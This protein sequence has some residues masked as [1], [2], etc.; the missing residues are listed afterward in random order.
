M[1]KILL[2]FCI[3]SFA[4]TAF[5]QLPQLNKNNIPAV[6][7]A[8]TLE[9]K[10]RLIMGLGMNI[11]GDLLGPNLAPPDTIKR[12]NPVPGSAGITYAVPRLG[13]PAIILADGPAGLRIDPTR[14][15]D[16]KK[17]YCTAFP[18]GTMLAS[19]WNDALV[20]KVGKAM[21]NEV[22]E[23]GVD[24]YLAPALNTH[25]NVLGGRNFEYYSEDPLISGRTAAAYINGVQ[26][27]GVGTSIK[28]FA[29][30]NH[31]A[32]RM[33]ID[34]QVSQRAMRE[35]YLRGFEYAIT[36]SKPWTVMSSYNKINGTYTSQNKGLITTILQDEWKFK[37]LVVTDW[38]SGD[39]GA[40]Q[41]N[42]GNHMIMPGTKNQY[43]QI[44]AASKDGSLSEERL[45][46]NVEK[47]LELILRSNTFKKYKY[48]DKPN[49][50]ENVT[51]AIDAATEGIV[52]LKN[53]DNSLP[54]N[55]KKTKIALLG[56]AS[57]KTVTGGSGSGDVNKAYS[58]SIYQGL[59]NNFEVN[60]YLQKDYVSYMNKAESELPKPTIWFMPMPSVAEKEITKAE[61]Q[62]Y[63]TKNDV[64]VLTIRRTSGEFID[65]KVEDDYLLND[66]EKSNIKNVSEAFHAKKKKLIVLLNIGGVIEM[67]SWEANADAILLTWQGGQE[68]GKA[69]ASVVNGEVN[70]SG[71]LA[72]TF[73]VKYE[74]LASAEGFPGT[75]DSLPT[76]VQYRDGIYVGYR[77][78]EKFKVPVTY[79]FGYGMSYT[80]FDYSNIKISNSS[81]KD[82]VLVTLDVTNTGTLAGKEVV[83]LYLGAPTTTLDKPVKELKAFGKTELLAPGKKVKM[84]FTINKIDLASFNEA[85]SAWVA[86][87]GA[88]KIY[89]GASSKNIKL[90]TGFIL[91]KILVVKKVNNVLAPVEK[92]E[93][94]K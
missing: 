20:Q 60:K 52:L 77:Y 86:D 29:A 75:P 68:A 94:L 13:I 84:T 91:P 44:I 62:E 58:V 7:K 54:I 40:A 72:T 88:Y 66:L 14:P 79:E 80:K 8:L 83:E 26:S 92:I 18:I 90:T 22:K 78:F 48:S 1:K 87:A 35:I 21:G 45:N 27:N 16:T 10:A 33:K 43:D 81:F 38:F 42:A 93:E 55:N 19:T 39:D 85:Q 36:T 34:V 15:N 70:P 46:K 63:A 25:R 50:K 17:Y 82:K 32:N 89:V 28:H 2:S 31:E 59:K 47:V 69:I 57:Y 65:R 23:R 3:L 74:D 4:N 51:A 6:V 67:K 49:Y 24:I 12:V 64:A 56:N 61:A 71:K 76:S 53:N 9:E 41:M 73:P 30:N 5:A 11:P 37:G